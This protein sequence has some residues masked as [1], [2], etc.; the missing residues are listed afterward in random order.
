MHFVKLMTENLQCPE[1]KAQASGRWR[2][3]A[4]RISPDWRYQKAVPQSSNALVR[5]IEHHAEDRA[6]QECEHSSFRSGARVQASRRGWRTV[7]G[8]GRGR[9]CIHPHH[10]PNYFPISIRRPEPGERVQMAT[11]SVIATHYALA[12]AYAPRPHRA[13]GNAYLVELLPSALKHY[14]EVRR[15]A[16]RRLPDPIASLAP[17]AY[18]SRRRSAP[19]GHAMFRL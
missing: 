5:C 17:P 14:K 13:A 11:Y 12:N 2:W 1:E 6:R 4:R 18:G 3:S 7:Y 10:L 8:Q 16:L 15:T 19:N 9:R